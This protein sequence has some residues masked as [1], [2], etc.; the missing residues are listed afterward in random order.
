MPTLAEIKG[1]HSRGYLPH[2]DGGEVP[3]SI[4]FRLVDSLPTSRL[5]QWAEE[6][7]DLPRDEA[8]RE[9]RVRV[10]GYLDRGLGDAW[11]KVPE[12]ARTVEGALLH[13][14]GQRYRLHAWV[15]M[16]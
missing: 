9:Y 8:D 6:L 7:A 16:P 5:E 2:F 15:V 14:D 13:F 12:V 1:W 11:L 4:T 3:Q 10:E